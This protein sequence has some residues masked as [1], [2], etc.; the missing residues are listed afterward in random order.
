MVATVCGCSGEGKATVTIINR[1]SLAILN[2]S[3]TVCRA[4]RPIEELQPNASQTLTLDV[5]CDSAYDLS[6]TFQNGATLRESV[7][8]VCSGMRFTDDIEV[9]LERASLSRIDVKPL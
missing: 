3:V 5:K 9:T 6:V 8:Y 2:G 1:S 7:G 4:T